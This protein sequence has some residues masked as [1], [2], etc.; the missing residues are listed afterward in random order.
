MTKTRSLPDVVALL[1]GVLHVPGRDELSLLDVDHALAH[2]GG[3]DQVGLAAEEGGDL[4][5]VGDLGDRGDV[6]GFVH[7]GEDRER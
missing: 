2:G 5:D 1:D 3:D 7:V 6:S 4:Q